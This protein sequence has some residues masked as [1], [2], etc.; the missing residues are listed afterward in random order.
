MMSDNEI[1]DII[2][3]AEHDLE[4]AAKGLID[5]AN[6][7]GGEDN[8]TVVVIGVTEGGEDDEGAAA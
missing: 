7:N 6:D 8:I 5:R 4:R 2:L 1:R 3:G